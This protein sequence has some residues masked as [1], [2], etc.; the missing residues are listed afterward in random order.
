MPVIVQR[1]NMLD[2][3]PTGG[4]M[5]PR[6]GIS[7]ICA[8]GF[9]VASLAIQINAQ[10]AP[11]GQMP[12]GQAQPARGGRGPAVTPPCGPAVTGKNIAANSRCFEL[13]TYTVRAEGPGNLDLLH[14]RFRDATTKLFVKHGMTIVGFWQPLTK[15]DTLIY[16]MAYKDNAARDAEWA[17]FGADPE[18]VKTR[19]EMNVGTQVE[20]VFLNATDYSPIK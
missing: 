19:T 20:S 18:W 3:A 7:S 1:A 9:V 14:S 4:F 11:A 8:F 13:R 12:A 2:F 16:L 17:A 6:L 10:N 5:N 15:P